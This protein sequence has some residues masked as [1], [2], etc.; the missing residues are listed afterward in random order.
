MQ[1]SKTSVRVADPYSSGSESISR[2]WIRIRPAVCIE[3]S[4]QHMQLQPPGQ[5]QPS[6]RQLQPAPGQVQPAPGQ[7]KNGGK[8]FYFFSFVFFFSCYI[9]ESYSCGDCFCIGNKLHN[10]CL[11][12][13][14]CRTRDRCQSVC[15]LKCC[16]YPFVFSLFRIG[17]SNRTSYGPKRHHT[18]L[19]IFSFDSRQNRKIE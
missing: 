19:F 16:K 3:V 7:L 17:I 9:W 11:S 18:M 4:I 2:I 12:C 13:W 1:G 6:P 14:G 5:V 10:I 15:A 8:T